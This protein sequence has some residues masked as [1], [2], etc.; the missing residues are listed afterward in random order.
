MQRVGSYQFK[1][2]L[3]RLIIKVNKEIQKHPATKKEERSLE[4]LS[5]AQIRLLVEILCNHL[6]DRNE[7]K[8]LL[9]KTET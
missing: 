4:F 9:K 1:V 8:K 7:K 6:N 3:C 2:A 5:A